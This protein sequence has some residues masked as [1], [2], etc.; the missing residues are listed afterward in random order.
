MALVSWPMIWAGGGYP[1]PSGRAAS[2]AVRSNRVEMARI[3]CA[4]RWITGERGDARRIPPS[5]YHSPS[6]STASK[7]RGSAAEAITCSTVISVRRDLRRGRSH[8]STS[9][10]PAIQVTDRPVE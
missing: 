9:G 7:K 6:S 3:R 2:S 10:S 5:P 1:L 8:S 4:P